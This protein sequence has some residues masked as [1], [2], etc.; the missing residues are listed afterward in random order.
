MAAKAATT[1]PSLD[2]P[3]YSIPLIQSVLFWFIVDFRE[4]VALDMSPRMLRPLRLRQAQPSVVSLIRRDK[5]P[6]TMRRSFNV[7]S[8]AEPQ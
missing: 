5:P 4:S 2:R 6:L 1:A 3:K 8:H 7:N